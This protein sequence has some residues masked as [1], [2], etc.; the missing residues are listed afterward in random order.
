LIEQKYRFSGFWV[1][2]LKCWTQNYDPQA[3]IRPCHVNATN[4]NLQLFVR[5][6]NVAFNPFL[7]GSTYGP[8]FY[9]DFTFVILLVSRDARRKCLIRAPLHFKPTFTGHR[10]LR[11]S[12]SD[13]VI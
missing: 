10:T 3:K 7:I 13:T 1:F 9:F 11:H 5:L 12:D 8:H 6:Q 2:N 4:R